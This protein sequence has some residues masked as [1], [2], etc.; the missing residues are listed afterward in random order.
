[1]GNYCIWVGGE[2][3]NQLEREHRPSGR[4][5]VRLPGETGQG[6]CRRSRRFKVGGE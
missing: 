6:G 3:L 2:L 1:M 4:H 5:A